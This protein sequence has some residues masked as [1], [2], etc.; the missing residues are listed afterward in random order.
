ML[1]LLSSHF[2]EESSGAY[3]FIETVSD[4]VNSVDFGLEDDFE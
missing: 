1:S 3:L 4:E 2:D